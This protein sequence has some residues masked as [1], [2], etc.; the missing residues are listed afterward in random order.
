MA[1]ETVPLPAP[2]GPS[3]AI[4]RERALI[5][6][7]I[8]PGMTARGKRLIA[9]GLAMV[10]LV[11][12]VAAPYVATLAF[13]L[14]LAGVSGRLRSLIPVRPRA[15]TTRD[16]DVPTRHGAMTVRVYTPDGGRTPTLVVFPGIHGGGVDAVRLVRLCQRM[17]ASG[18]TVVCSPLPDLRAF[19]I[20]GRSTDMIE[21]T[22]RWVADDPSLAP[23]GTV[24]LVGVSFAGGLALI[25]AGRPAL[26]DHLRAVISIG[27]HGD[28]TRTLR[29]LATG[30]LPDGSTRRPH[31]YGL[32]VIALMLGP[33]LVP[34]DQVAGFESGVR[35]FLDASLDSG[36]DAARQRRLMDELRSAMPN[37]PEPS[38]SLVQAIADRDVVR[39]GQAVAPFLDELGNDPTMSPALAPATDAPVFLLHG[40]DDNVIPST[41]TPL[42]AI[43]LE[44]RG[45]G[46]VRWLLTPLVT[47]ANLVTTASLRDQWRLIAFWRDARRYVY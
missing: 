20:T 43:D 45:H 34:A 24:T 18:L 12:V 9:G 6:S 39:V 17:S 40:A 7:T 35:T 22:T 26:Q 25:A 15:V 2:D 3:I 46:R 1:R 13:L 11:A 28:L 36:Q 33:K 29:F 38:R 5:T 19:Q 8:I 10:A 47:H 41:E 23:D 14:D 21:D 30:V 37:M 27:G 42:A 31:D 16:I 44:D 32:A 4:T